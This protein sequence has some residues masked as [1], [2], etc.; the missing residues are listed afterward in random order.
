MTKLGDLIKNFLSR[1]LEI[2][3]SRRKNVAQRDSRRQ[4]PEED[5]D[6]QG[7]AWSQSGKIP[8][9][10]RQSGGTGPSERV[11]LGEEKLLAPGAAGADG[12]VFKRLKPP[13]V[14][15]RGNHGFRP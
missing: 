13:C 4:R 8:E 9:V 5:G 12:S 7:T 6:F 1:K 3:S 15:R 14:T 11:L 10:G 2:C